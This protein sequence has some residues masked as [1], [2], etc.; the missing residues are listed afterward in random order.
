ML[1]NEGGH[2]VQ[3]LHKMSVCVPS[4]D[5]EDG[6]GSVCEGSLV[7]SCSDPLM[8]VRE[9]ASLSVHQRAQRDVGSVVVTKHRRT[10]SKY[11]ATSVTLFNSQLIFRFII[12]PERSVTHF[13]LV[14]LSTCSTTFIHCPSQYL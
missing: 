10:R 7:L 9:G 4:Q 5:P 13:Q 8:E 14:I 2:A 11:P 12:Y 3:I 1:N 6:V